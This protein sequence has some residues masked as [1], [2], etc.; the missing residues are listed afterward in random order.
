MAD[1]INSKGVTGFTPDDSSDIG[2]RG[3]RSVS[4]SGM[5]GLNPKGAPDQKSSI[6]PA[7]QPKPKAHDSQRFTG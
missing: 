7:R 3:R 6:T 4:R 1:I 2:A 5:G